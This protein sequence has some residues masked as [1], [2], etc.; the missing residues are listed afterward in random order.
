[1][2]RSTRRVRY[3]GALGIRPWDS[4]FR[5]LQ[6]TG[7][8]TNVLLFLL[9]ESELRALDTRTAVLGVF[10][11]V[12]SAWALIFAISRLI[13]DVPAHVLCERKKER[14]VAAELKAV[15]EGRKSA[16]LDKQGVRPPSALP[17]PPT[18][19][20]PAPWRPGTPLRNRGSRAESAGRNS[21]GSWRSCS[22]AD[23]DEAVDEGE[24][25]REQRRSSAGLT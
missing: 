2:L 16:T 4:I 10:A 12:V 6:L 9:V 23:R 21:G 7:V 3:E 22:A 17:R 24:R 18:R 1:M 5:F 15:L 19:A 14:W 25:R 13:P 20:R 8:V 11:V